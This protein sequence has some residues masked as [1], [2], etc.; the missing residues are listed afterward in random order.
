MAKQRGPNPIATD[1]EAEIAQK[2]EQLARLRAQDEIT[3]ERPDEILEDA[4]PFL[5]AKETIITND[6]DGEGTTTYEGGKKYKLARAEWQRLLPTFR[7]RERIKRPVPPML[8]P[9]GP[10]TDGVVISGVKYVPGSVHTL[11]REHW[12]T[13]DAT[14]SRFEESERMNMVDR[15]QMRNMG[16]V[17]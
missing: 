14:I 7:L 13:I 10:V 12:S 1:L 8:T 2:Q 9:R 4:P 5:R 16:H 11:T 15:G 17:E 6:A 3:E